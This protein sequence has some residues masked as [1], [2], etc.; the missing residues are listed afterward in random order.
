M[1]KQGMARPD[2]PHT[3]P[4]NDVSPVPEIQGKTKHTKQKA[5]PIVTGTPGAG[6]KVYHTVDDRKENPAGQKS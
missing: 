6:L 2:R 4:R 3:Q 5:A 1:A